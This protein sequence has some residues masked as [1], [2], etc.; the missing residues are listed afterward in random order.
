MYGNDLHPLKDKLLKERRENLIALWEHYK[1]KKL[2]AKDQ[3]SLKQIVREHLQRYF[4]ELNE[5]PDDEVKAIF[6]ELEGDNYDKRRTEEKKAA[7]AQ[8]K[9]AL[10]RMKVDLSDIDTTDEAALYEKLRK[11][12][13]KIFEAQDE[14]SSA[15]N[16]HKKEK[17]KS[18]KQIAAEKKQLAVDE[19]K[20]K[21]I[22]TI[23]KQLAKLFHPD[24]EQDELRK[25]EKVILM[26][27]LI[28][29]YEAKNLHALL[30]LELKWIHKEND[31]LESLTEEKLAVYLQILKEQVD[32]L[33]HEKEEI[34]YQ[35]QYA[36]LHDE[37]GWEIQRAPIETIS[38][39]IKETASLIDNLKHN[40]RLY[41]SLDALRHI[42]FMIKDWK[43][44]MRE[45]EEDEMFR[46]LFER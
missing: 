37:F 29:A 41:Q 2:S 44:M 14:E 18:T 5:L 16:N 33:T 3:Q 11:H 8:L 25:A 43:I 45:R 46:Q 40:I 6:N 20:N 9:A 28:A 4:M 13:Q 42:K 12:N 34:S 10:K 7:T 38:K 19:L 23:Y 22:S 21:N 15:I 39:Y 35:P 1:S 30:S 32:N 24:L 31:H 27:E 26:Q 17:K 36:I